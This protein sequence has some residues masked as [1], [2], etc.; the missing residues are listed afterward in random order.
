MS[1]E[2]LAILSQYGP[3]AAM[4]VIMYFLF[5][6]PQKKEQQKR[7]AMLEALKKNDRVITIGG[8]YGVIV[9]ISEKTVTLKVAEK[10]E[11]KFQRSAVQG[12]QKEEK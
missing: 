10:V 1:P 6:R 5:V 8:L 3:I 7:Q 2:K 11:L 12:L 9:E 4:F